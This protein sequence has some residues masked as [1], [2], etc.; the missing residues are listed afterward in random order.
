M[1]K[2]GDRIYVR[3]DLEINKEDLPEYLGAVGVVTTVREIGWSIT[4]NIIL[5]I[6]L[7]GDTRP[8]EWFAIRFGHYH[9]E[10][11]WEV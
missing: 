2:V 9:Q 1:F 8:K 10:P 4:D 7:D 6:L 3:E 11:D 5:G